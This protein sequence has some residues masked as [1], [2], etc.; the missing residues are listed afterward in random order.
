[1]TNDG[2]AILGNKTTLSEGIDDNG[3]TVNNH[4][5]SILLYTHGICLYLC[6]PSGVMVPR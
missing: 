6:T 5:T 1:M 3:T 4:N 2:V